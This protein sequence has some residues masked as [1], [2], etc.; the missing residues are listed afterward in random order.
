MHSVTMKKFMKI[1]VGSFQKEENLADL[2]TYKR[3]ILKCILSK[4]LAKVSS[5]FNCVRM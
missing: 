4:E 1:F 5:G 3:I 2:Y